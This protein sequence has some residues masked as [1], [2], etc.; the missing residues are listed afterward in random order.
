MDQLNEINE[1]LISM[2]IDETTVTDIWTSCNVGM[3]SRREF[4]INSCDEFV[5]N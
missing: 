2:N 5:D 3:S 1:K 4:G